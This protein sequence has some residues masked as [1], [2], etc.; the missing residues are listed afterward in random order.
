ML[1]LA[2]ILK[3]DDLLPLLPA[4]QD[5]SSPS[6]KIVSPPRVAPEIPTQQKVSEQAALQPR[7][8]KNST[9][10]TSNTLGWKS[11]EM[12]IPQTRYKLCSIT[13]ESFRSR[14]AKHLLAQHIYTKLLLRI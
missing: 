12:R 11:G 13:P 3:R 4:T 10:T 1:K 6:T 9:K 14:A 7:V 8:C 5:S 2:T